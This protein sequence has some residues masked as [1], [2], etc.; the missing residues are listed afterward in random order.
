[1]GSYM[2]C[3]MLKIG[4]VSTTN[5]Q[6]GL[7]CTIMV[8]LAS[9]AARIGWAAR[10]GILIAAGRSKRSTMG[11][12]GP[13]AGVGQKVDQMASVAGTA[14]VAAVAAGVGVAATVGAAAGMFVRR[15]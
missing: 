15:R 11:M 2:R 5:V 12:A 10:A 14:L 6:I 3:A 8:Q 7:A 1:M 4:L 9:V 13:V